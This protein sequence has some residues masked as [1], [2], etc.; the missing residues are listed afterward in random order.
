MFSV[1]FHL[2]T[3]LVFYCN[4]EV[5]CHSFCLFCLLNVF[6]LHALLYWFG[7]FFRV[8]IV[9][10]LDFFRMVRL[11]LWYLEV[12]PL[13]HFLEAM[14]P[15]M[16]LQMITWSQLGVHELICCCPEEGASLLLVIFR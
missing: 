6:A 7:F 12:V 13:L 16:K 8:L 14:E 9:R 10:W 11:G 5:L 4:L 15:W 1:L 3:W 2:L